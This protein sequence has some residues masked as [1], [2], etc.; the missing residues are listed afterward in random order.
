M[1]APVS[2]D[3]IDMEKDALNCKSYH[4]IISYIPKLYPLPNYTAFLTVSE[5]NIFC[6]VVFIGVL[7]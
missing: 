4:C 3:F 6:K 2:S 1:F 5:K 7:L